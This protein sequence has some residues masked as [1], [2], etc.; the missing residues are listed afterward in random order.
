MCREIATVTLVLGNHV[1][2]RWHVRSVSS[3]G[4]KAVRRSCAHLETRAASESPAAGQGGWPEAPGAPAGR[5][6]GEGEYGQGSSSQGRPGQRPQGGYGQRSYG[7]GGYGQSHQG[8]H[9]Q[10]GQGSYGP[11]S[12]QG[13]E[14]G[15]GQGQGGSSQAGHYPG[16]GEASR[17][18]YREEGRFGQ[19]GGGWSSSQGG[20]FIA[21]GI[22]RLPVGPFLVSLRAAALSAAFPTTVIL[23]PSLTALPR[24]LVVLVSPRTM[25]IL[26]PMRKCRRHPSRA[27]DMP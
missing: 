14:W 25:T 13:S 18:G 21:R 22:P 26:S 9:R 15:Y 23:S 2:P 24:L 16:S 8:P 11:S 20:D 5:G 10:G 17:Y 12:G 19:S 7:Q 1:T 27:S 3:I 4:M 6:F